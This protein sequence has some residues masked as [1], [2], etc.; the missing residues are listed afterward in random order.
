MLNQML[1]HIWRMA[2]NEQKLSLSTT[3]QNV[4]FG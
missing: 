1:N 4:V 2:L 3:F